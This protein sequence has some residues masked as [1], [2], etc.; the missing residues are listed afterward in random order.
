MNVKVSI[1]LGPKQPIAHCDSNL[2]PLSPS[3]CI[4][5][6][7]ECSNTLLGPLSYTFSP[8]ETE[9]NITVCKTGLATPVILSRTNDDERSSSVNQ[10]QVV[11]L[12]GATQTES[13]G[14]SSIHQCWVSPV[15]VSECT[16]S[17]RKMGFMVSSD[18]NSI[19]GYNML[20]GGLLSVGKRLVILEVVPRLIGFSFPDVFVEILRAG[21]LGF[22]VPGQEVSSFSSKELFS[23]PREIMYVKDAV[24][25][26]VGFGETE[27]SD[28]L[29][30]QIID[31]SRVCQQIWQSWK[32]PLWY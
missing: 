21:S 31:P 23:L 24:D 4:L 30:L 26:S 9:E 18:Q 13:E 5:E 10:S 32:S 25:F 1:G 27:V 11:S 8:D 17:R 19:L 16:D 15:E 20:L 2:S 12:V 3:P 22:G 14:V 29:P 28:C 7:G 6:A